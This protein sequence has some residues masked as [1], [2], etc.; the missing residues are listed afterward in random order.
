MNKSSKFLFVFLTTFSLFFA[1]NSAEAGFFDWFSRF[2]GKNETSVK[3]EEV[4]LPKYYRLDVSST[5]FGT[6]IIDEG[7]MGCGKEC[8]KIFPEKT[9]IELTAK[10]N[11]DYIFKNWSGCDSLHNEICKIEMNK[12]KSVM[13]NF[14]KKTDVADSQQQSSRKIISSS[15]ARKSSSSSKSS[16]FSS[17]TSSSKSSSASSK[18]D[19]SKALSSSS[20]S[21]SSENFIIS[22]RT[23]IPWTVGVLVL[24]SI[25]QNSK[26]IEPLEEAIG[27]VE[28]FSKFDI[29]YSLSFSLFPHT[30]T[31]YD[32]QEGLQTCVVVNYYDVNDAVINE[33]PVADSYVIFW[34]RNNQ[35]PLQGGSTW[36]V[37][38]G[39]FKGGIKRPYATIP[40]D[41]WWYDDNSQENF[42][43][44]S[45][46]IIS[47]ELINS[48][49]AKLETT[50]YYCAPLVSDGSDGGTAY[51]YE[52]DRLKKLTDDCY[53]KYP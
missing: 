48:I 42:K 45:A 19:S 36:G 44:R 13:A 46:Q 51:K 23:S 22:P 11:V 33:L 26:V 31:K 16:Q 41:I 14:V 30:Y 20:S 35:P 38:E 12:N 39:I 15:V 52:S 21:S 5:G 7:K 6:V 17:K 32:C 37:T 3:K 24:D 47:H 10:P 9:I 40:V 28:N 53:N 34:N 29:T 4:V 50:P 2:F 18:A 27:F 25:D 8:R 49:N 43:T 1:F